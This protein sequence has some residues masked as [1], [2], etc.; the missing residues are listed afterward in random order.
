MYQ[1][2]ALETADIERLRRLH[3]RLGLAYGAYD[4]IVDRTG[5]LVFLEVNPGGQWLW[6]EEATGVPIS[7]AVATLLACRA[8]K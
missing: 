5:E 8:S 3:A 6:L 4:L 7:R 2:F 1:P